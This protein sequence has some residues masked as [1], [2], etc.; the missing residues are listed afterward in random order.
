MHLRKPK[1][2]AKGGQYIYTIL[3]FCVKGKVNVS[4]TAFGKAW[5]LFRRL[6]KMMGLSLD[7]SQI[8]LLPVTGGRANGPMG[9]RA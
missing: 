3:T 4:T 5:L 1:L 7:P 9:L 6:A 8:C 2:V